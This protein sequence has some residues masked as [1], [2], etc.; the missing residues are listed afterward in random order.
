MLCY[1]MLY[2]EVNQTYIY[3]Y[4]LFFGFPSHLGLHRALSSLCYM[5]GIHQLSIGK[6]VLHTVVYICQSQSSN[7][8]SHPPF[9]L[10][11]LGAYVFSLHLCL[12]F[13]NRF[14]CTIFSRFYMYALIYEIFLFL[15]YFTLYDSLQVHPCLCNWHS[16][17]P[18]N[19]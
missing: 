7:S 15:T 3:I 1:F 5:A 19:D 16:F 17:V 11:M 8:S 14:I 12:C 6:P 13:V 4:P 9:P 18:F 2:S 10:S